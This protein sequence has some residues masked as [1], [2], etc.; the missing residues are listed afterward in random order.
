MMRWL[1]D[2]SFCILNEPDPWIQA[3]SSDATTV[4]PDEPSSRKSRGVQEPDLQGLQYL[5]SRINP[6]ALDLMAENL[7]SSKVNDLK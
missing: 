7:P 5:L 4:F 3:S 6:S 1:Y 2:L